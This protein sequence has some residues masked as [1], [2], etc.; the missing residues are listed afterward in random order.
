MDKAPQHHVETGSNK[1]AKDKVKT[2]RILTYMN[3]AFPVQGVL[4][5]RTNQPLFT[6]G[7]C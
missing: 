5:E 7:P 1:K 2:G 3:V 4:L 6:P